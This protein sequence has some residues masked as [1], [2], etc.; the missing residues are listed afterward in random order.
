MHYFIVSYDVC[1][2]KRLKKVFKLCKNFGRPIQYSVFICRLTEE[3]LEIFK[4]RLLSI[5]KKDQDQILFIRLKET[6]DGKVAKNAFSIL[7][8][9]IS[10]EVPNCWIIT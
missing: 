7:G 3:N 4:S 10:P 5:I 1:D 9:Q 6:S 2:E 8:K